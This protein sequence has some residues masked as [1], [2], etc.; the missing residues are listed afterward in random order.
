MLLLG[1][2]VPARRALAIGLVNRVVAARSLWPAGRRL[3]AELA[4]RAPI[5]Q[6]FAKEALHAALDLPLLEGLRLEGDLY[7]LLQTT[8]DRDEGIASFR[9]KRAPR[10]RSR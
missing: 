6:R 8:A 10:Y 2:L 1:D 3:A 9:A 7:V 5:A 4:A